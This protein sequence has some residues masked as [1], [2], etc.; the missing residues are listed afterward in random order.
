MSRDSGA[1]VVNQAVLCSTSLA[2]TFTLEEASICL[3]NGAH[4]TYVNSL[5][6]TML[7]GTVPDENV[8]W[9]MNAFVILK[10]L[11]QNCQYELRN[12]ISRCHT[13]HMASSLNTSQTESA[14]E[15]T[16]FKTMFKAGFVST[17]R[18]RAKLKKSINIKNVFC[19]LEI[20]KHIRIWTSVSSACF[21][22]SQILTW[23]AIPPSLASLQWRVPNVHPVQWCRFCSA[24]VESWH[25]RVRGDGNGKSRVCPS[26]M[27]CL[28]GHWISSPS[29]AF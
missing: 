24:I 25:I 14:F 8:E 15:N 3:D 13:V 21:C 7:P 9:S 12:I 10:V 27:I 5:N 16:E 29:T 2:K 19:D 20:V 22:V 1:P 17:F 18:V 11:L 28:I 26:S 6:G 4:F 23:N